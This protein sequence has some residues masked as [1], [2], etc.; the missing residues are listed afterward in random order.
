MKDT[1]VTPQNEALATAGGVFEPIA[2]ELR[3]PGSGGRFSGPQGGYLR[4]RDAGYMDR[5]DDPMVSARLCLEF[6]LRG[7]ELVEGE[8]EPVENGALASHRRLRTV[9]RVNGRPAVEHRKTPVFDELRPVEPYQQLRLERE[10]GA[11]AM[12]VIDLVVPIG[13]GQ[14]GLIVAPPGTGR[15]ILLQQIAHS[16]AANYPNMYSVLLLIDE[17]P[18]EVTQIRRAVPIEVVASS[19]DQETS[20]HVRTASLILDRAKRLVE[21]GKDAL[22]LVDSMTNLCRA[23]NSVGPDGYRRLDGSVDPAALSEGRAFL[24][25]ARNFDDA[26]SLTIVGTLV[27]GTGNDADE[28]IAREIRRSANLE[29]VLSR[30]LSSRRVWPAIDIAASTS[31]QSDLFLSA[32]AIETMARVRA[33]LERETPGD[34]MAEV[35]DLLRNYESNEDLILSVE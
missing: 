13:F 23:F 32:E 33:E 17:R 34:A 1:K 28:I 16:V 4:S 10:G 3:E 35:L 27:T 19:S 26:G 12:R 6:R 2:A 15:T 31:S 8:L 20:N 11:L 25:E 21:E 9:R 14:R 22:L 24:S 7:G 29:V 5:T 30:E 18:E